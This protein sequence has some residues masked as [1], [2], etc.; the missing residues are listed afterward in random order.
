VAI[1]IVATAGATDANSY[2][3]LAEYAA[4]MEGRLNAGAFHTGVDER[5][6]SLVEATRELDTLVWVGRKATAEQALAWPRERAE[7]PDS[8]VGVLY[9]DND[10]VPERVKVATIELAL[11][12]L[13]AGTTDLAALAKGGDVVRR[14]IDVIETEWAHPSVRARGI[15]RFPRVMQAIGPL[16]AAGMFGQVRLV[17]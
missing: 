16:L 2:A 15:A 1:T 12:F 7:S 5:N 8:P 4:Y 13:R 9:Y 10:V 11:E 6:R 17:R 14:K 3:T